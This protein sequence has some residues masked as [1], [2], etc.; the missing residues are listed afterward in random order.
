ML[1]DFDRNAVRRFAAWRES[2]PKVVTDVNRVTP[3]KR[4]RPSVLAT[5][6]PNQSS[7]P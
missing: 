2:R 5:A 6:L 7:K 4:V 1:V 3:A